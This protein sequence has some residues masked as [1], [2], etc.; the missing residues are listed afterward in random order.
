MKIDIN[1]L[2]DFI[3]NNVGIQGRDNSH[4]GIEEIEKKGKDKD[5]TSYQVKNVTYQKPQK[6]DEISAEAGAMAASGD[7]FLMKNQMAVMS[8]TMTEEDCQKM[9]EQGF[10]PEDTEIPVIVTVVDEIKI[11]L[12]KAGVDI[13]IFGDNITSAQL[14]EVMGDM[15]QTAL[16]A[17]DLPLTE[18][19]VAESQEALMMAEE[20]EVPSDGAIKYM[21]DNELEPTIENLFKAEHSGSS[22]YTPATSEEIDFTQLTQQIEKVL[23]EA[24]YEVS[25]ENMADSKWLIENEI[26]LTVENLEKYQQLKSLQLPLPKEEVM[27]IITDTIQNGKRPK[28]ALLN[29]TGRRKLEEARLE[30]S[31]KA[32]YAHADKEL[33]IDTDAIAKTVDALKQ[34][35]ENF[36][37]TF[38]TEGGVEAT[39]ENVKTYATIDSVVQELKTLPA[40]TLGINIEEV[41]SAQ[42]YHTEGKALEEALKQAGDAYETLMTAPRRDMGDS[43]QKAF[44]NVDDILQDLDMD[45]TPMNE[46]AVRIL[47]Y[48]QVEITPEN[49]TRMKAIDETVQQ[50]FKNLTPSVVREMIKENINPLDMS[51]TELNEAALEIKQQLGIDNEEERFSKYLYKLEQNA[52]IAEEE[53]SAYIGIYRLIAQVEKTDGAALGMLA[54]QGAD[55]TMRNLLSSVRSAKKEGREYTIDDDFGGMQ[56]VEMPELSI[57][58][59]IEVGFQTDCLKDIVKEITPD[60]MSQLPNWQDMTSEQL[61]AALE[62][63]AEDPA[64]QKQYYKEQLTDYKTAAMASEEVYQMLEQYDLPKTV[65]SVLAAR[66]MVADRNGV[67]R[68][69]FKRTNEKEEVNLKEVQQEILESFAEAVKTPEDMAKAQKALA[70][71]ATNVMKTMENEPN[72]NYLD[73]KE[74]RRVNTQIQL[75]TK[76]A[77]EETYHIPVLVGDSVTGVSL[78]IVRGTEEKGRVDIIFGGEN[79]GEVAARIQMNGSQIQGAILSN[80]TQTL[81]ALQETEDIFKSGFGEDKEITFDYM[82]T[83]DVRLATAQLETAPLSAEDTE[84]QTREL[85]GIAQNFLEYIKSFS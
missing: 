28:D 85:Y 61:K 5:V 18:E 48:N 4:M 64:L 20:L 10:S 42:T 67:F 81:S 6:E 70:D 44:R 71:V 29:I 25:D 43:I 57:I 62:Q 46:R 34:A 76:M 38:L 27:T 73:L 51:M 13:S 68:K 7:P 2:S 45:I 12:A 33:A 11:Q 59:Q 22:T 21:L 30:M 83:K 47:A 69:L 79:I 54:E 78:K 84:V 50:T 75:G 53:R 60:K 56:S 77:Q 17:A 3:Q 26:P 14:Q 65:S 31:A 49:I 80:R 35:E 24:G 16:G 52:Q 39:E 36:Y 41:Q 63:Q 82:Q 23:I 72:I 1:Q 15:I 74:M 9:D 58:E 66:E 40:Y 32:N 55:F 37:K 8:N 19:N